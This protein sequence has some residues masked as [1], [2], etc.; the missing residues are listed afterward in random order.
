MAPP[1]E[2]PL[3]HQAYLVDDRR[4]DNHA[5]PA[6]HPERPERLAAAREAVRNSGVVFESVPTRLVQ[7]DEL[8][9]VHG[10]RFVEAFARLKGHE[11]FL[12]PD[13]YVAPESVTAARLAAGGLIDVVDAVLSESPISKAVAICRPPG[14]HA[15]PDKSMG[16]CLLNNVA[17]AAAHA[18]TRGLQR[19]AILDWDAHHGNGTQDAFWS[20]PSVLYVSMHQ[21]PFYPGTGAANEIG[22][23]IGRG[24][25]VNVPLSARSQD[26]DYRAAMEQVVLPVLDAYQPELV[27]ISAGFDASTRDPLAQMEVSA[28]AFGWMGAQVAEIAS[29]H[30]HG[31]AVLVLEGGYDLVALESGLRHAIHGLVT[32][33]PLGDPL[34]LLPRNPDNKDVA[35]AVR[36]A[37]KTWKS[38]LG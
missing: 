6:Y 26:G 7:D 18:K 15:T 13:T 14:H 34:E 29:K 20:D 19:I 4:F 33:A 28:Q 31:K 36:A 2:E 27:L 11:G 17:I 38:A 5:S 37:S 30:S 1:A 22:E 24:Y 3:T 32:G 25:T 23:G 10:P 8:L 21:Y 16:F 35:Q 12:D 9:R